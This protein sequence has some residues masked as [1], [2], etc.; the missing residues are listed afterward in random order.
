MREIIALEI[1]KLY[2]ETIT[3]RTETQMAIIDTSIPLLGYL[4]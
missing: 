1:T 4:S 3:A 2:R